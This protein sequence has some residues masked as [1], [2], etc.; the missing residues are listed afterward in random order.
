MSLWE[1]IKSVT[2]IE[3][4]AFDGCTDLTEIIY[5]GSKVQWNAI[6]NYNRW[7]ASTGNYTIKCT[8]G[9]IAKE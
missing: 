6:I 3:Y 4:S 7:N 5:Q 2:R 9:D 8:D 1:R